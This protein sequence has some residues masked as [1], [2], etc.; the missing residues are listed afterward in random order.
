MMS[1]RF[2]IGEDLS[3]PLP[4]SQRQSRTGTHREPCST[5]AFAPL[6]MMK[7]LLHSVDQTGRVVSN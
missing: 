6:R 5:L 7:E 4:A 2:G 3:V 1:L